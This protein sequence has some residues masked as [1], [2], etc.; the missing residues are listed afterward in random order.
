LTTAQM[1]TAFRITRFVN[2]TKKKEY[3]PQERDL[4]TRIRKERKLYTFQR[5]GKQKSM[6]RPP[7]VDGEMEKAF[8]EGAF[9]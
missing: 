3:L 8:F 2:F 9:I 7:E 6:V 4:L 5:K 1:I